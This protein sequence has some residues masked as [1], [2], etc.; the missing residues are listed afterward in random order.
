ME[1]VMPLIIAAVVVVAVCG[2][3]WHIARSRKLLKRWAN[4]NN[5]EILQSDHRSLFRG[6]FF[7]TTTRGQAVYFVRIRDAAGN[8]RTGWVRCGSFW[9]GML[10]DKTEVRWDDPE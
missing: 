8:V 3:V 9:A 7:W 4:N 1:Q 2:F 5:C 6:P 10:S